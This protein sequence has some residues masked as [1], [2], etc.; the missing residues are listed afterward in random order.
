MK[1]DFFNP[2]SWGI[3][4]SIF[5]RLISKINR[6]FK[7]SKRES[8]SVVFVDD[9][10]IHALNREH[11]KRDYP[12]DVLSFSYGDGGFLGEIYVSVDTVKSQALEHGQSLNDELNKIFVHGFL[13]LRGF[14]H[15]RVAD[16]KKM[17]AIE[18]KLLS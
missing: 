3:S 5:K 6:A 8:M 2:K 12:T 15:D 13:H 1:V 7:E 17:R 18:L 16:T 11:M 14:T 4:P 10:T 9:P